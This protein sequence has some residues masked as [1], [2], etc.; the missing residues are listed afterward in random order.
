M[1]NEDK[2][3]YLQGKEDMRE[4]VL[5]ILREETDALHASGHDRDVRNAALF[6]EHL[7]NR[8]RKA[9]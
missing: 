7:I 1:T 2:E 8:V 9:Y 4:S 5:R 3:L 6:G